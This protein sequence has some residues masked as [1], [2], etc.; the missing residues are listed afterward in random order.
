MG[1]DGELITYTYD[2][3]NRLVRV[4]DVTAMLLYT[5]NGDGD[6][7]AK[8]VDGVT[9]TCVVAVL[10]ALSAAEGGWRRCWRKRQR[11]YF[12]GTGVHALR[13]AHVG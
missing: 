8:A 7:V 12:A 11:E 9:T 10:L 13:R 1:A 5:Y 2:I 4:Q 3:A 6:R